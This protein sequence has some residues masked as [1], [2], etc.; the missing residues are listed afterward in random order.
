[1]NRRSISRRTQRKRFGDVHIRMKMIK[2]FWTCIV[3]ETA[4]EAVFLNLLPFI[5]GKSA[6]SSGSSDE[7]KRNAQSGKRMFLKIRLYTSKLARYRR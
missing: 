7:L 3:F 6:V 5:Y 1:M 4:I 2:N